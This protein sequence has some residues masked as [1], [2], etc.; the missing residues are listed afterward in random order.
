MRCLLSMAVVIALASTVGTCH[1]ADATTTASDTTAPCNSLDGAISAGCQSVADMANVSGGL[2]P[3]AVAGISV[4]ANTLPDPINTSW[5]LLTFAASH[6]MSTV[7]A[8][9]TGVSYTQSPLVAIDGGNCTNLLDPKM[10]PPGSAGKIPTAAQRASWVSD[11]QQ[12]VPHYSHGW[13]ENNYGL[14][15]EYDRRD[16][17]SVGRYYGGWI[18]DSFGNP[19]FYLG[20]AYQWTW[21]NW[22]RIRV[23]A[24]FITMLWR[25]TIVNSNG[26]EQMH[27]VLAGLPMLSVEDKKT[28]IGINFSFI[29]K[30]AFGG[31]RTVNT[32]TAQL[33][34]GF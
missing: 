5:R 8:P 9:V 3:A 29:P 20:S 26:D 12:G 11:C 15:L 23:D 6:H 30:I 14:G 21:F 18:R 34:I 22:D 1:A 16:S 7:G 28:G 4:P 32:F 33:S 25:R 13:D 17:D 31:E 2:S 27:V 19:S 24:G 10:Y